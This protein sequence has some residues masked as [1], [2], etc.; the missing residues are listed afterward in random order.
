MCLAVPGQIVERLDDG[1]AKVDFTGVKR[2]VSVVFT[3]EAEPGDWV[4]VH[5]G[6][7]LATIDEDEAQAT[8]DLL[9]EAIAAEL[10]Q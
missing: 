7:A 10:A 3:P 1:L 2:T 8:L 9:G 5:V 6:F 4:L